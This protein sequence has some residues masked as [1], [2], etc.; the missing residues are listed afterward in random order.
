MTIT[1]SKG[2]TLIELMTVTAV[3][4][5]LM[6]VAVPAFVRYTDRARFAEAILAT[7]QYRAA[8]EVAANRGLFRKARDM[9]SGTLGV[10]GF[11]F[12]AQLS[13][14]SQLQFTG[15]GQGSIWVFWGNDGSELASESYIQRA[16]NVTPPIQ[17]Q[18][19]G[20][21]LASGYC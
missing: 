15:V 1:L 4:G 13:E 7:N 10:P 20:S 3:V 11:Q 18:V 21:C 14:G 2:F 6:S 19:G 16:L 12:D 17:W 8:I 9:Y 5:L